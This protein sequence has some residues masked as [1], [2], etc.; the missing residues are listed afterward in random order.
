MSNG[1]T[2]SNKSIW[3]W[4]GGGCAVVLLIVGI[5]LAFGVYKGVTC[6]QS[7]IEQQR[8]ARAFVEEFAQ[9]L[10]RRDYDAAWE[11]TSS[12]ME[13]RTS[14]KE[15]IATVREHQD[16]I[17]RSNQIN[18]ESFNRHLGSQD[19]ENSGSYW[20]VELA[21]MPR[22]GSEYVV[23]RLRL[24]GEKVDQETVF[25]VDDID[26]TT[27]ERKLATEPP[28]EV[29]RR[30]NRMIAEKKVDVARDKVDRE[31]FGPAGGLEEF[32]QFV[33]SHDDLLG[34]GAEA[35][36]DVRYPE[37]NRAV[38]D[39][40]KRRSDG[41]EAL[42]RYQLHKQGQLLWSITDIAFDVEAFDRPPK[43]GSGAA[44]RADGGVDG[45]GAEPEGESADG[46]N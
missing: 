2:K 1:S 46:A 4:L 10:R 11:K 5:A 37:A 29:V 34:G 19:P 35:V 18:L 17:L 9:D 42:V 39:L 32:E 3:L 38:V 25:H 8:K 13:M 41:T 44:E 12:S 20:K 24:V 16:A 21:F 30:F 26:F 31:A 6:C 22:S 23:M 7:T 43:K 33:A 40:R 28:A 36:I 14:R 15:F 45:G 27:R